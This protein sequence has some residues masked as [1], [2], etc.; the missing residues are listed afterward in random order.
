MRVSLRLC[1]VLLSASVSATVAATPPVLLNYQGVLRRMSGEPLDGYVDLVFSFWDYAAGG[2]EILVDSHTG[3]SGGPV[4]VDGGLFNATLGGGA[5]TDGSGPGT[6]LSLAEVFR[7]HDDVY[8]QVV[9]NGEGLFP[10]T[11]VASAAYALNAT[12][13]DGRP[14]SAF[15]DVSSTPQL[16]AGRLDISASDPDYETLRVTGLK[17]AALF[18]RNDGSAQAVLG[19]SAFLGS[20][21]VNAGGALYGGILYD[22]NATGVLY[23]GAGDTGFSAYG[24]LFGGYCRD[25]DDGSDVYLAYGPYG[26]QAYGTTVGGYLKN[27][28]Y[29]SDIGVAY[30]DYGVKANGPLVG[31]QFTDTDSGVYA[32]A[33]YGPYTIYGNGSKP[34]VQNH[35]WELDKVVVYNALE[36]DEVGTYTRGTA[37]LQDGIAR[38]E[39]DPTFAWV[40]N[41]DVG[42]TVHLTPIDDW[43]ELYV[44]SKSTRAIVVKSR[45]PRAADV[46]FDYAVFGLRIGFEEL[47]IVQEKSSEARIPSMADDRA[48]YAAH[49]ELRRF[50]ALERFAAM[51][52][53][54]QRKVPLDLSASAALRAAVGE[55]DPAVGARASIA[56]ARATPATPEGG[57]APRAV[58]ADAASGTPPAIAERSGDAG[59]DAVTANWPSLAVAVEVAEPVE[60]GDVLASDARPSP[61]LWRSD[62][63]ANPRVVGIVAGEPHQRFEGR[64][65]LAL[66]G[67]IVACRADASAAP[68]EVGDLLVSGELPG[69]AMRAGDSPRQGTV[70]GKALEALAAGTGSIRVLVMP[71]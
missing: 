17:G 67:S 64:V 23:G 51:R 63:A 40:T 28:T 19:G 26:V 55:S 70:L 6:Y 54:E 30:L 18:Q 58:A 71:R 34:F 68:I 33:A 49:P 11:R 10:R 60:A 13:L 7:D 36:G 31:G 22:S 39:L 38:I 52:P 66:A 21:G 27:T 44:T 20:I 29:G 56:P 5:V 3:A 14:A 50:N 62:S 35:P 47:S 15:L 42:L 24:S 43:A 2:N 57:A 41:P 45:D 65:P 32:N 48:R 1:V 4:F 12:N 59:E 37:R 8:L 61:R 25:N 9:V 16:K 46:S 69:T 53:V